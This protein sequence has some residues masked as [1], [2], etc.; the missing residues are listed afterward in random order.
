L[1]HQ[2]FRLG[3]QTALNSFRAELNFELSF[4]ELALARFEADTLPGTV[5]PS[6]G[7]E[8]TAAPS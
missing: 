1:L 8:W 4:V 6:S 3:K 5:P 2:R 7:K